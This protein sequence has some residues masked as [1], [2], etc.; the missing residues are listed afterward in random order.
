M[1]HVAVQGAPGHVAC[2]WHERVKR[3][4]VLG[5]G[6]RGLLPMGLGRADSLRGREAVGDNAQPLGGWAMRR[7]FKSAQ[8]IRGDL[9]SALQ[10][11]LTFARVCGH[12]DL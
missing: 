6:G 12:T 1:R 4:W 7:H 11:L 9:K 2:R 8:I 5:A 10:R 3:E